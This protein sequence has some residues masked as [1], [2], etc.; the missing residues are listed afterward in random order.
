MFNITQNTI[1]RFRLAEI[2]LMAAINQVEAEKNNLPLEIHESR[3]ATRRLGS[4]SPA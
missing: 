3:F 4:D 2:L 1:D